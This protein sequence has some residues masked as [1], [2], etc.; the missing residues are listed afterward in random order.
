M[1]DDEDEDESDFDYDSHDEEA[2]EEL[3]E[4]RDSD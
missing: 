4:L 3:K 1:A 2:K